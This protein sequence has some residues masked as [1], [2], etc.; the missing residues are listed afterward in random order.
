MRIVDG[1][2]VAFVE[3]ETYFEGLHTPSMVS[4]ARATGA[5]V[6]FLLGDSVTEADITDEQI[7]FFLGAVD[8]GESEE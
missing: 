7:R 5:D 3:A 6:V 1:F 8:E 2:K 4:T